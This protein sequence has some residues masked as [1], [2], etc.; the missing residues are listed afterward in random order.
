MTPMDTTSLHARVNKD[1]ASVGLTRVKLSNAQD[2]TL[3]GIALS[4][5]DAIANIVVYPGNGMTVTKANA[6][7]Y[8]FSK[9]PANVL[10]MDYQG[11][12]ASEKAEKINVNALRNDAL[13]VY[14]YA[15]EVFQNDLPVI[16]H[17][18]SMGSILAA[19]VASE[20]ELDGVVLDGA[21]DSVSALVDNLVPSWSKIFTR[22]VVAP[23]LASIN[24]S[25]YVLEYNGPLLIL[26][27]EKD[28][29]TPVPDAQ[30]LYQ[31]SPS[32][33][34]TLLIIPDATHAKTMKYDKTIAGYR[35]F[36]GSLS[37]FEH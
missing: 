35:E 12:G 14:E 23:E 30:S 22:V 6:F 27:G 15:H 19:F 8:R 26:A 33:N 20:R 4:Y 28:T 24:N 13:Q 10:M 34:K 32:E 1:N 36:I 21:I 31:Q 2:I 18:V 29:L 11:M 7:L 17:G 16:V 9:L 3:R 25:D 5:P 37:G